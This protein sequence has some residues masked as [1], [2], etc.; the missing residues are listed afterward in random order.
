MGEGCCYS[1]TQ[2][3]LESGELSILVF[4]KIWI[5]TFLL[6]ILYS[7][8]FHFQYAAHMISVQSYRKMVKIAIAVFVAILI[9]PTVL[10][11]M[12]TPGWY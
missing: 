5:L 3:K 1:L 12:A 11:E 6:S 10:T 9:V 4:I 8:K 2:S 7:I